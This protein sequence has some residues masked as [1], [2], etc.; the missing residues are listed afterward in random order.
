[1]STA[2]PG[3]PLLAGLNRPRRYDFADEV[4]LSSM[5]WTSLIEL[6]DEPDRG[7]GVGRRGTIAIHDG[8]PNAPELSGVELWREERRGETLRKTCEGYLVAYRNGASFQVSGDGN[9]VTVHG[10]E[11]NSQAMVEHLLLDQVLPRLLDHRGLVVL[12][13][14]VVEIEGRAILLLG[15]TGAGKSTLAA[16]LAQAGGT[17]LSDD[18][19]VLD[20]CGETACARGTYQGL[21]LW[22]ESA[23]AVLREGVNSS[24]LSELPG[25]KLRI[26]TGQAS[27]RSVPVSAVYLLNAESRPKVLTPLSARES[28]IALLSNCFVL[29]PVDRGAA[30]RRLSEI[31]RFVA[32][33]PTFELAYPREFSMLREVTDEIIRNVEGV[34]LHARHDVDHLAQGKH[35]E[36]ALGERNGA[37]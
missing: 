15:R 8:G 25:S 31:G 23:R 19:I 17:L 1:M 37:A 14:A 29:D 2:T 20:W 9:A 16:S 18:A 28:C 12:H 4:L 5:E 36:C 13:G 33:V 11:A 27:V 30:A 10:G 22:P 3:S 6:A 32:A 34:E 35:Q 26:Q 24:P 7:A 21:R